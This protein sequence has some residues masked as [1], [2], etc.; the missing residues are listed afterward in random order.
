MLTA[1]DYFTAKL[2]DEAG[3]EMILVGDSLGMVMLGYDDTLSVTME[4]MLSYICKIKRENQFVCGFSME[5]ENL[6]ENS[7]QKLIKKNCDMIAAN[8]LKQYGA[9]FGTDTN[10]L[11]LITKDSTDELPLISKEAAADKILDRIIEI[12]GSTNKI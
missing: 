2:I 9:G 3:V 11:T 4:D 6:I 10:I 1:Y 7:R 5:T 12:Q 8:N